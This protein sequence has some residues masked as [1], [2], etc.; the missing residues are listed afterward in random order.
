MKKLTFPDYRKF[1]LFYFLS[2]TNIYM[3]IIY[4]I[5]L[6]LHIIYYISIYIILVKLK[7][8]IY[9]IYMYRYSCMCLCT[10]SYVCACCLQEL[11]ESIRSHRTEVID[12]CEML[13]GCWDL[14]L[15]PLEVELAL[16]T[17][18]SSLQLFTLVIFN[19]LLLNDMIESGVVHTWNLS[20][21]RYTMK[22]TRRFCW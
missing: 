5:I 9:N 6:A 4:Y 17:A 12:Y 19:G 22:F 3:Y 11:E 20:S 15:V 1:C 21:E 7:N 2:F 16:L 14:N 13:C 18:G 8:Y 10:M